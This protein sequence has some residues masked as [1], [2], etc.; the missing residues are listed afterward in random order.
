MR[1]EQNTKTGFAHGAETEIE[2]RV[3]NSGMI[4]EYLRNYIY[5]NPI[6]ALTREIAANARDAH[7]EA[8]K[9][10]EPIEITLPTRWN[11]VWAAQD[12][13][14]GISPS[15]VEDV[16]VAFGNS[17]KRETNDLQG[18]Y[19]LG[20]KSP[21]AYVDSFT[22]ITVVDGTKYYWSAILD[23]KTGRMVLHS[24]EPTDEV[25]GT[26]VMVP[27]DPKDF[28][29]FE[30]YT[31]LATALWEVKPILK[32]KSPAP[33]YPV[34]NSIYRSK[35]WLLCSEIHNKAQ[36]MGRGAHVVYDGI[37]YPIESYNLGLSWLDRAVLNNPIFLYF[38]TGEL[39]LAPSRDNLRYS[40]K[41]NEAI[42]N[43][44]NVFLSE[45]Q[46]LFQE[47]VEKAPSYLEACCAWKELKDTVDNNIISSRLNN[48]KWNDVQVKL[49][50]KV[51]DIGRWA[52]LETFRLEDDKI[53]SRR[54]LPQIF[55]SNPKALVLFNAQESS[56]P[57]RKFEQLLKTSPDLQFIQVITCPEEPK[58]NSWYHY[59]NQNNKTKP[60]YNL[61]WI[62]LFQIQQLDQ[63]PLPKAPKRE[64]K[65]TRLKVSDGN[66]MAYEI[67]SSN[68]GS[69]D[70]SRREVPNQGG[71]YVEADYRTRTLNL[72]PNLKINQYARFR[73]LQ[74][75]L[76]GQEIY[77]F[78]PTR[79]KKLSSSWVPLLS[80]LQDKV[81]AFL[82]TYSLEDLKQAEASRDWD[83][84]RR[85]PYGLSSKIRSL[86]EDGDLSAESLM[87][88]YFEHS[89]KTHSLQIELA[90]A[91]E[92]LQICGY[93]ISVDNGDCRLKELASQVEKRYELILSLSYSVT[94]Q[95]L[96]NY[97][98]LVDSQGDK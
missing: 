56:M 73:A 18:A 34:L 19:G 63:Y 13:G 4:L 29:A 59:K 40:D 55:I 14:V 26:K 17:T 30:Q 83:P 66:V 97:I 6:Q 70:F 24:S 52:K 87:S 38:K 89:A 86:W 45:I 72:G 85:M 68:A 15:R 10:E 67:Y 98:N 3:G 8:G 1:L 32:G 78:T 44:L 22:V 96:L 5:K 43:K 57:R 39:D 82:A 65:S 37:V 54:T 64:S 53:K 50:L 69:F 93:S 42:I 28:E 58:E 7:R 12:W 61:D 79:V 81:K 74:S 92:A 75:F 2:F 33:E 51:S 23:G 46:T 77:G 95:K 94:N 80:A 71:I 20:G 21:F 49:E 76:E 84:A 62:D 47:K 25:N 91:Q 60:S 88:K 16:F 90:K 31:L 9:P 35:D 36:G 27:V 48:P 41:T 11:P